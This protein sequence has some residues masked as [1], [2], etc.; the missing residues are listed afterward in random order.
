[1][2][3]QWRPESRKGAE[4]AA[5]AYGSETEGGQPTSWKALATPSMDLLDQRIGQAT[6]ACGDLR[7]VCKIW[8]EE[9]PQEVHC[10][11][12]MVKTFIQ[13]FDKALRAARKAKRPDGSPV[14]KQA[15][16]C[17]RR[18]RGQGATKK[19]DAKKRDDAGDAEDDDDDD[20]DDDDPVLAKM[21]GAPEA[22]PG[23]QPAHIATGSRQGNGLRTL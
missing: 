16:R 23:L 14:W 5:Q 2:P 22:T 7:E 20:D 9:A 21:V 15:K 19:D 1:M 13:K 6:P 3:Y 11:Q 8:T 17:R 10:E 12:H 4:E 18:R